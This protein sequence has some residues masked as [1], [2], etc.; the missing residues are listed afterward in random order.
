MNNTFNIAY[1][2]PEFVTENDAGGLATYYDNVARLFADAGSRVTIFVLSD[3]TETIDYYPGITVERVFVDLD[4]A[5]PAV[6]SS[7]MRFWSRE[8]NRNV[9]TYIQSGN[10][11]DIVQYANY[12]ALGFERLEDTPTVIRISSFQPYMRAASRLQFDIHRDYNCETLAD[13]LEMLSVL[14]ADTVYSPSCLLKS[15]FENETGRC[16]SVIE[17]PFYPR[18]IEGC[19][20]EYIELLDVTYIITFSTMNLLKGIKLIGD[21]INEVLRKNPNVFW[22]FAGVDVPWI[23]EEGSKIRPSEYIIGK[24]G[25]YSDR[26]KILGK[27]P[28][29]KLMGLLRNAAVCVMPSRI[30]NLP[31]TCIEAMALGKI[32]IGTKGASFDQLIID[33]ENGF[34]CERE[35]KNELISNIGKALSLSPKQK[36]QMGLK[37]QN[38]INKMTPDLI[39]KELTDLY[40]KTIDGFLRRP[41]YLENKKYNIYKQKYNELLCRTDKTKSEGYILR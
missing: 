35:N 17:S 1:V 20:N 37:A 11:I 27:I 9:R 38:R 5:D 30:D 2:L 40:K 7:F 24:A 6:P 25:V 15:I 19:I 32:V 33:G 22:V 36:K 4:N 31:N 28:H 3:A 18:S 41:F 34:L 14:K 23:D 29:E 21:S 13:Y 16:V 26:V 12:M 10:Q 39:R 8:M